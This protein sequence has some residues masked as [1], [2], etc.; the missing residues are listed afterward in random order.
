MAAIG[1]GFDRQNLVQ[2]DPAPGERISTTGK[3]QAPDPQRLLRH[4]SRRSFEVILQALTP[5]IERARIV[6]AQTLYIDN[7]QTHLT[8]LR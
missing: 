1:M 4:Q 3:V 2:V 8:D 6:Q 5:V 7:L